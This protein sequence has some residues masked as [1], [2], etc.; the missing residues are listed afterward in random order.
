MVMSDSPAAGGSTLAVAGFAMPPF[1]SKRGR[2][3]H[4]VLLGGRRAGLRSEGRA[5]LGETQA[6]ETCLRR[7][8]VEAYQQ[9]SRPKG[10]DLSII[11]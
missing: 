8:E 11:H 6:L 9:V 1:S 2:G 5:K 3:E 10:R 4:E 7:I